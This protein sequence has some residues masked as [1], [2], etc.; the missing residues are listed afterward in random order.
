MCEENLTP[1]PEML[2]NISD[3]FV[4][5]GVR[6]TSMEDISRHL[7]ISKKTLYTYFAD[8]DHLVG[9]VMMFRMHYHD[10]EELRR[11]IAP[12][13]AVE[14]LLA[15][16]EHVSDILE[17]LSPANSFDMKKYHL[18]T[19]EQVTEK[20]QKL[21]KEFLDLVIRKGCEEGFFRPDL[22][23]ELQCYLVVKQFTMLGE[24]DS[25][26][27]LHCSVTELVTTLFENLVRVIATPKG[28]EELERIKAGGGT[29]YADILRQRE[30]EKKL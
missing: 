10:L 18:A 25:L 14:C 28:M 30:T 1:S 4:K 29:L 19:Y 5:Y 2:Q 24:P 9:A 11:R 6:S 8:K 21:S 27:S 12:Y 17:G 3:I 13:S 26:S 7:K 23:Y 15:L 20:M 22:N 16:S